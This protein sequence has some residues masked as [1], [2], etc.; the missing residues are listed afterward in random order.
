MKNIVINFKFSSKFVQS[1]IISEN[2]EKFLNTVEE[3][4]HTI[5]I[6]CIK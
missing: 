2:M 4:K 1:Y 6:K 3:K 5:S